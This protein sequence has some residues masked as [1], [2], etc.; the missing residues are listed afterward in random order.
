[1]T[2]KCREGHE[3]TESDYC[4]VCGAQMPATGAARAKDPV[5]AGPGVSRTQGEACPACGEPRADPDARFCEVCRYDFVKRAAGPPPAGP[6]AAPAR[7]SAPHPAPASSSTAARWELVLTVDPSI[8]TEP[9]PASPPPT[10]EP[11]RIFAIEL[12]EM[13]VGR[14]DD[15]QN[16][17]PAVP[18][19]DPGASR[20]HAKIL[21]DKDGAVRL[22]DLASMNGT[23]LNGQDVVSG[24]VN[25]LKD[26]DE[27]TLGRWTRI[28]LRRHA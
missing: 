3:S 7:P 8:D 19:N 18:L 11:E 5:T 4:S 25:P 22:Q 12:A 26:G 10:D 16:I 1:M 14:R 9:D 27:I 28:R 21:L 13:L 24:S 20:R 17:R 2:W 6:A 23:K 15:H